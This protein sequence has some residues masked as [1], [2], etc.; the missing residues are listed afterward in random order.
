MLNT[1]PNSFIFCMPIMNFLIDFPSY[2]QTKQARQAHKKTVSFKFKINITNEEKKIIIKTAKKSKINTAVESNSFIT[3]HS[4]HSSFMQP[5]IE[6]IQDIKNEDIYDVSDDEYYDEYDDEDT[7]KDKNEKS[8]LRAIDILLNSDLYSVNLHQTLKTAKLINNEELERLTRLISYL[9]I[10]RLNKV[11]KKIIN[12]TK[13]L[14]RLAMKETLTTTNNNTHN[15]DFLQR[16]PTNYSKH[17][18]TSSTGNSITAFSKNLRDTFRGHHSF[19]KLELLQTKDNKD[20][21]R[22][23][24]IGAFKQYGKANKRLLIKLGELAW[25]KFKD[26]DKTILNAKVLNMNI[27]QII[28]DLLKLKQSIDSYIIIINNLQRMIDVIT[29][30]LLLFG[31]C[32]ILLLLLLILLLLFG[33]T[34]CIL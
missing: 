21:P 12:K 19:K 6:N 25:K 23:V 30:I 13:S 20:I 1:K 17:R 34:V 11:K 4:R 8:E 31:T 24:F 26:K 10:L 28:K 7:I 18:K 29:P 27:I 3:A 15:D 5:I 22:T 33:G 16:K 32:C 2:Q 9:I 14:K